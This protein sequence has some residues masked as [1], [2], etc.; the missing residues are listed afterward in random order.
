MTPVTRG[1]TCNDNLEEDVLQSGTPSD[2]ITQGRALNN[3]V[4]TM[5]KGC[6]MK[7]MLSGG[8]MRD[9]WLCLD[10]K[11]SALTVTLDGHKRRIPLDQIDDISIGQETQDQL[12]TRCDDH[13]VTVFLHDD[14]VITLL[15]EDAEECDK[16]AECL[17]TVMA[18]EDSSCVSNRK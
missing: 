6:K 2:A 13:C 16:F 15:F 17:S 7:A 14:Q 10:N 3:F 9:V 18:Q 1:E 8:G 12:S 4:K 5:I 11:L